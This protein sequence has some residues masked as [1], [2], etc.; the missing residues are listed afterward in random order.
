MS[1]SCDKPHC[2]PIMKCIRIKPDLDI[3]ITQDCITK[4]IL[5][6][7]DTCKARM[8]VWINKLITHV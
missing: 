4:D 1:R 8:G 2:I 6:T 3:I 5:T 7:F